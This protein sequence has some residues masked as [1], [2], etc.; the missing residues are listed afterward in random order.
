M[1]HQS[2]AGVEVHTHTSQPTLCLL[3]LQSMQQNLMS[4]YEFDFV[5]HVA[6]MYHHLFITLAFKTCMWIRISS[7]IIMTE[8]ELHLYFLFYNFNDYLAV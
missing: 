4:S 8:L 3:P 5:H 1:V 6:V 2:S 7:V